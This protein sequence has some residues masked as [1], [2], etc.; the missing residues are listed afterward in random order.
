MD[1]HE[2]AKPSPL[3]SCGVS[4]PSGSHP[5]QF[6]QPMRSSGHVDH[7]EKPQSSQMSQENEYSEIQSQNLKYS[8]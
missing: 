2:D 4:L 8:G 7:I 1:P 3:S 5:P 6:V